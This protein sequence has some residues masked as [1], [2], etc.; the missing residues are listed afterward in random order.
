MLYGTVMVYFYVRGM[1]L[2]RMENMNQKFQIHFPLILESSK[3][4]SPIRN[5]E[6]SIVL[7]KWVSNH[8][9]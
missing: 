8:F 3:M 2:R 6:D 1:N 4:M 7:Q 9:H 5:L